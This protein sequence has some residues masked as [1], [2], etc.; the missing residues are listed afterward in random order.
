MGRTSATTASR[1]R[2]FAGIPMRRSRVTRSAISELDSKAAPAGRAARAHLAR[3]ERE[4]PALQ[5]L[6]VAQQARAQR[7]QVARLVRVA[8]PVARRRPEPRVR[9]ALER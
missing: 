4:R 5:L 7:E 1:T 2:R 8:G 9:Q 3:A 6:A